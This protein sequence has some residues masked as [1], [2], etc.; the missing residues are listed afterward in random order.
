MATRRKPAPPKPFWTRRKAISAGII[1]AAPIVGAIAA[2]FLGRSGATPQAMI[3]T[4]NQHVVASPQ[5]FV[6]SP[7]YAAAPAETSA[8][9]ARA[10]PE[11]QA[12]AG[13]R[14]RRPQPGSSDIRPPR[15]AA[16][17]PSAAPRRDADVR[18][19]AASE[20]SAPPGATSRCNGTVTSTNQTGG[21]TASCVEN[22][23]DS[24]NSTGSVG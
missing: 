13:P 18:R 7:P 4:T 1:L 17:T 20:A 15:V 6:G 10:E 9:A 21:I 3:Q 24:S 19:P 14:P 22:H 16:A 5:I 8:N 11:E 12:A 23:Y 2:A